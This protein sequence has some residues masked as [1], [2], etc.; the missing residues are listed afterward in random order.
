VPP[1]GVP[2]GLRGLGEVA[3]GA[4]GRELCHGAESNP[5]PAVGFPFPWGR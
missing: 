4:I 1:G 2:F 5:R 3:L